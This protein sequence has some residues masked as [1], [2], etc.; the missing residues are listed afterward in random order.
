LREKTAQKRDGS[1]GCRIELDLVNPREFSTMRND[2]TVNLAPGR[3]RDSVDDSVNRTTQKFETGNEGNVEIAA[4]EFSTKR[5]RMI[6]INGAPP[7]SVN[8]GA[9]VEIFNAAD[10]NRL[11]KKVFS[12]F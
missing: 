1:F 10:A 8:Q 4:I 7:P 12:S 11:H 5:C 9:S 2:N 3:N 6:K